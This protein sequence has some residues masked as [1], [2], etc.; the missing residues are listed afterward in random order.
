VLGSPF[1][2]LTGHFLSFSLL[3]LFTPVSL[4]P[5]PKRIRRGTLTGFLFVFLIIRGMVY[6]DELLTL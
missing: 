6:V 4:S 3:S 2:G 1:S 5:L